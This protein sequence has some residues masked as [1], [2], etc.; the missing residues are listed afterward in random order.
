MHH[1]DVP[2][3]GEEKYLDQSRLTCTIDTIK[4]ELA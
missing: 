2:R 1:I 3:G 4:K